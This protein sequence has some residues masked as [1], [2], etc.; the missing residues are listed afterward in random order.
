MIVID[1]IVGVTALLLAGDSF[2]NGY[3]SKST[4][5]FAVG[6]L[7]LLAGLYFTLAAIGVSALNAGLAI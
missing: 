1:L 2:G 7:E 6:V 5:I 4:G 3:R